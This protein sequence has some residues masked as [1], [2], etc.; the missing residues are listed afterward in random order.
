[1]HHCLGEDSPLRRRTFVPTTKPLGLTDQ[2]KK[3]LVAFLEAL[4]IDEPLKVTEPKLPEMKPLW[5]GN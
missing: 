1:V 5:T 3:D 2:E 4:S